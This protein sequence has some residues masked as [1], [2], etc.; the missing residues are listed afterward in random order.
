MRAVRKLDN[1]IHIPLTNLLKV[2]LKTLRIVRSVTLLE[3]PRIRNARRRTI[4]RSSMATSAKELVAGKPESSN[5]AQEASQFG[6]I[7]VVQMGDVEVRFNRRFSILIRGNDLIVPVRAEAGPYDLGPVGIG[8][9]PGIPLW[10]DGDDVVF[11]RT[12]PTL[13]LESALFI[14][15]RAPDN[16]YHWLMNGTVSAFLAEESE[17]IPADVPL[18]VPSLAQKFPQ[19]IEALDMVS[20]SRPRIFFGTADVIRVK[21]LYTV[22]PPALYDTPLSRSLSARKPLMA[23]T[24]SLRD[25]R[26]AIIT[27]CGTPPENDPERVRLHILKPDGDERAQG[28]KKLG[29]ALR[30]VGFVSIRPEN[31]SFPDQ[32]KL[33]SRAEYVVGP[34][35]AAATNILFAPKG[36]VSLL[37]KADYVE[38]E[39]FFAILSEIA[40]GRVYCMP[41]GRTGAATEREVLETL[42]TVGVTI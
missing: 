36:C 42:A 33:F 32:V 8:K 5:S 35:G 24:Q 22:D 23:H 26:N 34:S 31:M 27:K 4:S 7:E 12:R 20:S 2:G 41:L 15:S 19:F 3:S 29:S 9:E 21:N 13:H 18:L 17:L 25:F 6:P 38:S 28:Q 11:R 10:L 1:A 39:N 30:K 40:G 14:G 16:Y 37:W